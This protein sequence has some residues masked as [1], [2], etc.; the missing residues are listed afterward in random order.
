MEWR[1]GGEKRNGGAGSQRRKISWRN[2]NI[3]E[4]NQ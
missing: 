2:G 3:S 4:N 1:I